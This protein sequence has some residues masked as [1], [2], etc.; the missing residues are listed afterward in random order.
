MDKLKAEGWKQGIVSNKIDSAVKELTAIY[1]AEQMQV[2]VGDNPQHRRKPAPDNVEFALEQ[3]NST[4]E[5][6][7][8]IGDSEV[9]IMTAQ[10][11]G[12]AMII[13]DWGFKD[14]NYLQEKGGQNVVSSTAELYQVLQRLNG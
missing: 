9:D 5:R 11:A 13:V 8:F 12:T 7:I 3:L 10:N 14:K 2:A 1:F 6:T 4:R